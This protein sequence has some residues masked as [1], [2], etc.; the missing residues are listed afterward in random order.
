MKDLLHMLVPIP[1]RAQLAG[2]GCVWRSTDVKE[3]LDEGYGEEEYRLSVTASG[4][5][6]EASTGNGLSLIHI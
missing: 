4:I 6:L 5:R 1:R 3:V 2:A